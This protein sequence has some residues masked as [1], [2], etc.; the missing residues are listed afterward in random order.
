MLSVGDVQDRYVLH[1]PRSA[2]QIIREAGGRRIAG[3]L[4]VRAD[5]LMQWEVASPLASTT[6][7][8]QASTR[9]CAQ[10]VALPPLGK[11]WYL[12]GIG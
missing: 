2:R 1:D 9:G 7:V 10:S 4:M 12:E 11:D 8:D 3:R 5:L 6:V